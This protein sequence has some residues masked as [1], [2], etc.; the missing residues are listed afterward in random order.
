MSKICIIGGLGFIGSHL[1]LSLANSGHIA[2]IIQGKDA[3]P[4]KQFYFE[5]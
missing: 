2:G 4:G 5:N 3:K 1:S